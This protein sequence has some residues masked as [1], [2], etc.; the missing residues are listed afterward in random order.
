MGLFQVVGRKSQ[1]EEILKNFKEADIYYSYEYGDLFAK[2]EGGELL[3]AYFEDG[4]S[5]VLYPFIKR[6]VDWNEE[7]IYDIVTPYGYG[8][9]LIEGESKSIVQ[10]Y[11]LFEEYCQENKIITETIRFHPISKNYINCKKVMDVKYIRKTTAVDLTLPLEE[12]RE[13]YSPMNKRNIKRAIKEGISCY[14]A[15]KTQ[16][17]IETFTKL[18]KRTMDRNNAESFYYFN[19]KYF[20]ELF[21]N[22]NINETNLLFAQYRGEIIAG[23]IVMKGPKYSH[24][25]LGAS[26][27]EF[28]YLKPNNCLF[29]FMIEFCK[30]RGST[31]LHLGGGYQ[32]NDGLFKFKA[33]FTNC[34]NFDFFIGKRVYDPKKYKE[35]SESVLKKYKVNENYF[36]VYRGKMELFTNNDKKS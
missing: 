10:F 4:Y 33:S 5:K 31:H 36:P 7:D 27:T 11:K 34:N 19:K 21:K 25:H 3:T 30:R 18:Y 32:E 8:G 17:K 35:I 24:Y 23:V 20:F 1:W 13:T 16:E 29:D 6:K 14:V 15:E 22:T 28:L 9:P 2:Q 26:K 12:I